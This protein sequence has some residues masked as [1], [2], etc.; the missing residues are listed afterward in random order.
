MKELLRE[1]LTKIFRWKGN[2][3]D[4]LDIDCEI[5]SIA[6]ANKVSKEI[7]IYIYIRNTFGCQTW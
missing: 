6:E 1:R 4:F 2:F 7:Y 5:N 3:V